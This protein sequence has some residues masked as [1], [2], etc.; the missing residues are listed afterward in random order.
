MN[1]RSP[2]ESGNVEKNLSPL[3]AFPAAAKRPWLEVTSAKKKFGKISKCT[4]SQIHKNA[5]NYIIGILKKI[6]VSMRL[7]SQ[8]IEKIKVSKITL[9]PGDSENPFY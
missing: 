5:H 4:Q 8:H 2:E 3:A 9:G 7:S 6:R 1:P